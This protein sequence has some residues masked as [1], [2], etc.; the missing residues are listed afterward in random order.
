MMSG[1]TF[2]NFEKMRKF[3]AICKY[4]FSEKQKSSLLIN[5]ICYN[6]KYQLFKIN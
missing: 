2:K 5:C 4:C 1:N 3:Y 6:E